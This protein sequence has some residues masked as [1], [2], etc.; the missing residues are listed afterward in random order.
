MATLSKQPSKAHPHQPE[1]PIE[2]LA[3]QY[4]KGQITWPEIRDCYDISFYDLLQEMKRSKLA[5]PTALD[6]PPAIETLERFVRLLDYRDDHD[7]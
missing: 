5:L 4:A 2:Q 6:Y 3:Q 1:R 7:L